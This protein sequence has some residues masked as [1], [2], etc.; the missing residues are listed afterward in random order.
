MLVLYLLEICGSSEWIKQLLFMLPCGIV[1]SSSRLLQHC[2][3]YNT[4]SGSSKV[5]FLLGFASEHR[6]KF[7]L[8]DMS[9]LYAGK[10]SLMYTF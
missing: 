7:V 6:Q 2:F 4:N 5:Q 3:E 10:Q 9:V 8:I 1:N